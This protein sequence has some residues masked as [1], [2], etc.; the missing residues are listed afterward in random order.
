MKIDFLVDFGI[1]S[2]CGLMLCNFQEFF[3]EAINSRNFLGLRLRNITP[4]AFVSRFIVV[5]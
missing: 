3:A 2:Q 4:G 5:V 1:L